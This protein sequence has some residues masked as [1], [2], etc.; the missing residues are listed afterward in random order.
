MSEPVQLQ[1][2]LAIYSGRGYRITNFVQADLN[3]EREPIT[4]VPRVRPD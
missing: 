4:G 2:V 3:V 1:A